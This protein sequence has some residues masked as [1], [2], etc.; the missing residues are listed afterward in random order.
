M[1]YLF[2]CFLISFYTFVH[3]LKCGK[4]LKWLDF[5]CGKMLPNAQI[6]CGKV[7]CG[8][9]LCVEKCIKQR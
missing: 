4:M 8:L 1:D 5:M 2:A 6:M 9:I 7:Y 3:Y